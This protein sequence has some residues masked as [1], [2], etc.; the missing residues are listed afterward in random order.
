MRMIREEKVLEVSKGRI[1]LERSLLMLVNNTWYRSRKFIVCYEYAIRN[2][3]G[4]TQ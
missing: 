1:S 2:I 3:K 4:K